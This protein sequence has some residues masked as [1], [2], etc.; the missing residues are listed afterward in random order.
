M[1]EFSF[2]IEFLCTEINSWEGCKLCSSKGVN[3]LLA[4]IK[5]DPWTYLFSVERN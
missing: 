3:N 1:L 2:F 5:V 4:N